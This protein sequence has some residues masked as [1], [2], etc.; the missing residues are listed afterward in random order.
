MNH[1]LDTQSESIKRSC[2]Y[3]HETLLRKRKKK[4]EK[5][6]IKSGN[7]QSGREVDQLFTTA[8]V[9]R[10]IGH[11]NNKDAVNDAAKRL[12][13]PEP[14]GLFKFIFLLST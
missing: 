4:T 12:N 8:N 14:L 13:L 1:K 6:E 11:P 9:S 7:Q 5:L 10:V 2:I 3:D